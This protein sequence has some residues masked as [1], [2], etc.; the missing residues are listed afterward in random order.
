MADCAYCRKEVP[1]S[2]PGRSDDCPHCA[3]PL[4]CCYQCRFYDPSAYNECR[5]SQAERVVEKEKP[6]FCDYFVFDP[7]ASRGLSSKEEALR[8][9]E[10]LFK[11]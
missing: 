8:K 11:K 5:E 7:Q 10:S 4:H 2:K 9:F 6:N 3:K 1:L